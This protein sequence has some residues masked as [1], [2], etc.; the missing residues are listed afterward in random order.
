[1]ENISFLLSMLRFWI[2]VSQRIFY[3]EGIYPISYGITLGPVHTQY[4]RTRRQLHRVFRSTFLLF[5]AA[6]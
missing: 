4:N 3:R 2:L 5:Q 6:S 1:M